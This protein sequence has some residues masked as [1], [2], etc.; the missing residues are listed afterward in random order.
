MA[1]IELHQSIRDHR[2]VID[3][4]DRL[5]IAEP[6]AAG[7]CVYLWT[8]ALDNA[9]DGVLRTST[10]LIAK[11]SGWSGD[12]AQ[13]FDALLVKIHDW[14]QYSPARIERKGVSKWLG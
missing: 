3:L 12:E 6:Y 7:L 1:W 5:E 11:A 10:R 9:P 13:L 4:A 2:K 8:W 14:E